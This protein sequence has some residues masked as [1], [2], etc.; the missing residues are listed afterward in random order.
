SMLRWTTRYPRSIAIAQPDRGQLAAPDA[1][2]VERQQ[3]RTVDVAERRPVPEH[4]RG[5]E[6][7]STGPVEPGAIAGRCGF[8][9]PL[10]AEILRTVRCEHAHPG[11]RIDY[12][13]Q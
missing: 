13:A 4:H 2:G 6:G 7:P 8:G 1:A 9:R 5:A 10:V 3:P 12:R 11:Q